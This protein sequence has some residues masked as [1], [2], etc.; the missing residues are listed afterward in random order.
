MQNLGC[1]SD[2]EKT[3]SSDFANAD[4]DFE[5]PSSINLEDL[6]EDVEKVFP[7][8]SVRRKTSDVQSK[9]TKIERTTEF[10]ETNE[11]DK[12]K[13]VVDQLKRFSPRERFFIDFYRSV[14]ENDVKATKA[15]IEMERKNC[16]GDRVKCAREYFIASVSPTRSC[17]SE[18]FMYVNEK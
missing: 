1:A 13:A 6:S 12:T 11:C 16:E 15:F 7:R 14:Y 2:D 18:V 10:D 5:K 17:R 3:K 9:Q 8:C 4:S